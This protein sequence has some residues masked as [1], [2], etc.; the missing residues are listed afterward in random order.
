MTIGAK[1]APSVSCDFNRIVKDPI[2]GV[3]IKEVKHIVTRNSLATEVIRSDWGLDTGNIEQA[4][5]VRVRV[6]TISGWHC[7]RHQTDHIFCLLGAMRLVL[8]DGRDDSPTRNR[9]ME[10]FLS[11]SR[12]TLVV[13]PTG[14]WHGIQ[15]L[16][17]QET[18]FMNFFNRVYEHDDPDEWRLPLENDTIPYR[19]PTR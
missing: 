13:I 2:Q 6:G 9:L 3:Q 19:F 16:W 1:D 12:P 5:L 11:D 18:M 15:N 7:H 4:L 10:L 17:H 8:F 14:V